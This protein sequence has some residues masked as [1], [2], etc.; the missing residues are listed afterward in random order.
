MTNDTD[1]MRLLELPVPGND[2]AGTVTGREWLA[3]LLRATWLSRDL[4]GLPGCYWAAGLYAPMTAA[5]LITGS[6]DD[7]GNAHDVDLDAADGLIL[8]AIDAMGQAP[9]AATCRD[10]ECSCEPGDIDLCEYRMLADA[11]ETAF[12]VRDGDEAEVALLITAIEEAGVREDLHVATLRRITR[13]GGSPAVLRAMAVE[14]LS[15]DD[16]ESDLNAGRPVLWSSAVAPGGTVCAVPDPAC[17]DGICGMPVESEPCDRH[18]AVQPEAVADEIEALASD[19]RGVIILGLPSA[20]RAGIILFRANAY[21][22]AAEQVREQLV[23]AWDALTAERDGLREQVA[24]TDAIAGQWPRCPDGCGCRLGTEDAEAGECGCDGPCT[25]EC[26][27]NGY[28]DASSYRDQAVKH[29]MD[30]RDDAR[31]QLAEAQRKLAEV[32]EAAHNFQDLQRIDELA[33]ALASLRVRHSGCRDKVSADEVAVAL[34]DANEGLGEEVVRLRD[35]LA[36]AIV[37]AA[38][39]APLIIA[40]DR[41]KWQREAE[42]LKA[43]NEKLAEGGHPEARDDG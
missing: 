2:T 19:T 43:E 13:T 18:G 14:A 20:Q 8:A 38:E 9:P 5:G 31:E 24:A 3:G 16:S 27:E 30:E 34:F 32:M 42:R 7:D 29:A 28:P 41:D 26:R 17:P 11:I 37:A 23:P 36:E 35:Q 22:K 40:A 33:R 6:Y 25:A 12:R 10:T 21:R 4:F 1:A 39:L 15:G